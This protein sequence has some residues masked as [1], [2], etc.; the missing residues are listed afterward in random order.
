[1]TSEFG[2]KNNKHNSA[3][4]FSTIESNFRSSAFYAIIISPTI[5][6]MGCPPGTVL[7]RKA[8]FMLN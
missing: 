5:M 1:L 7:N 8:I 3:S 2:Q 4:G 6:K